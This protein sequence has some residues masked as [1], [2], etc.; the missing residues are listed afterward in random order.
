[1]TFFKI[2]YYDLKRIIYSSILKITIFFAF[3]N[4]YWIQFLSN[5]NVTNAGDY[6][7][8]LFKGIYPYIPSPD[9]PFPFPWMW[10][11]TLLFPVI[12][13]GNY[14]ASDLQHY[15]K[16]VIVALGERT[17][18]WFSKVA[19]CFCLSVLYVIT[20]YIC[21]V[22][23]SSLDCAFQFD[24]S[25]AYIQ[26]F[27]LEPSAFSLPLRV[28]V[29]GTLPILLFW[30]LSLFH[31]VIC[32]AFN[33]SVAFFLAMALVLSGAYFDNPYIITSYAMML[34]MDF[35]IVNGLDIY[36]G[37]TYCCIVI[38]A[39]TLVGWHMVNNLDILQTVKEM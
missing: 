3:L 4:V 25:F 6:F 28:C 35:S 16:N 8:C 7:A 37:I 39:C 9:N 26:S 23:F 24:L 38:L 21:A 22:L 2:L 27:V 14:S 13:L 20:L 15:G 10:F 36:Q 29:L 18:W 30:A 19:L 33:S 31:S 17:S 11:V 32:I 12:I 34:K 5:S 1:M